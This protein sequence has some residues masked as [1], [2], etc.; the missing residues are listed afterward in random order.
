VEYERTSLPSFETIALAP[1]EL[2]AIQR[3]AR[4]AE[5]NSAK[6]PVSHPVIPDQ[7]WFALSFRTDVRR[8]QAII[9]AFTHVLQSDFYANI[10]LSYDFSYEAL[11]YGVLGA[12]MQ[13][14]CIVRF[15][16]VGVNSWNDTSRCFSFTG[17]M[18]AF[19]DT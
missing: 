18:S 8:N 16:G 5:D 2:A 9:E 19:E 7:Q 3:V 1:K 17:N 10:R 6:K 14:I 11:P 13:Q 4:I 12:N 15:L